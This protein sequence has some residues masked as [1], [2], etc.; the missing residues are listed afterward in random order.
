M[1]FSG[2]ICPVF[3]ALMCAFCRLLRIRLS[4][5]NPTVLSMSISTLFSDIRL[6]SLLQ[7]LLVRV[8]KIRDVLRCDLRKVINDVFV[9]TSYSSEIAYYRFGR[10]N[11]MGLLIIRYHY[12]LESIE[13]SVTGTKVKS[14]VTWTKFCDYQK[15]KKCIRS[16]NPSHMIYSY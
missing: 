7:E 3:R 14:R 8:G 1:S 6:L 9:F 5:Q 4:S 11:A 13:Q 16:K 10:F 2:C 12:S 15:F